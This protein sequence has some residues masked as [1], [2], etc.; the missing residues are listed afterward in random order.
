MIMKKK[1]LPLEQWKDILDF[2]ITDN[3]NLNYRE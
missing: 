3:T 2:H 1:S